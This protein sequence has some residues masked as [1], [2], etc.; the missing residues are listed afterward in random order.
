MQ[1]VGQHQFLMLLLVIDADFDQRDQPGEGV[2]IGAL[3]EFHYG[4]IDMP[5][6]R[7]ARP[8]LQDE[9]LLKPSAIADT[10]WYFAHQDRSAWT[11]ELD[12]RPFKEKF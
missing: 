3:E 8:N 1:D 10:F 6:L 7:N 9:D 12:V 11:H 5:L 2:L 4:G